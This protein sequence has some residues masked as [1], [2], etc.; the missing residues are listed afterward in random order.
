MYGK[1]ELCEKIGAIYPEIGE[2][3]IDI[4]AA[5]DEKEKTWIVDLKKG[6][7]LSQK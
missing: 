5:W 1:K 4:E 3:G 2:C 6:A 7:P